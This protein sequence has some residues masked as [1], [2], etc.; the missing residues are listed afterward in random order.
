MHLRG[1]DFLREDRI[2]VC[3]TSSLVPSV[4]VLKKRLTDHDRNLSISDPHK[5]SP[6]YTAEHVDGLFVLAKWTDDVCF[7]YLTLAVADIQLKGPFGLQPSPGDWN[8]FTAHIEGGQI[9][10]ERE[11]RLIAQS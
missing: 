7:S 4:S 10:S 1:E 2:V 6:G 11:I 8:A 3:N 5:M 9:V